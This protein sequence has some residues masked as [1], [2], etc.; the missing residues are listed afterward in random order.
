MWP[1]KKNEPKPSQP[2]IKPPVA[3][4]ERFKY[5]GIEMVCARHWEFDTPFPVVC[6]EYV[7]KNGEIK[8]ARFPPCDWSVLEAER[9]R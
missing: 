8:Y 1:F 4:G 6:A 7:N 9:V 5:L 2:E 3:I